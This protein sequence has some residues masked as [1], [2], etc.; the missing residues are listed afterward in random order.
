[1]GNGFFF[2][3]AVEN[4]VILW[5]KDYSKERFTT[6]CYSGNRRVMAKVLC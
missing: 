6:N 3:F 4:P 2:I 5:K 1:V